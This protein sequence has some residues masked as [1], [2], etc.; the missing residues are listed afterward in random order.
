MT[1]EADLLA[2]VAAAPFDDAPRLVLADWWEDYGESDRAAFVRVQIEFARLESELPALAHDA[3]RRPAAGAASASCWCAK[4]R[5]AEDVEGL[6]YGLRQ[7]EREWWLT[8]YNRL[9]SEANRVL[10]RPHSTADGC[11]V[12]W[13]LPDGDA[14][15]AWD[16]GFPATV[17]LPLAAFVADPA[18]VGRITGLTGVVLGD[19]E[20]AEERERDGGDRFRWVCNDG[21][22]SGLPEVVYSRLTGYTTAAAW[23]GVVKDYPTRAAALAALSAAALALAR[24]AAGLGPA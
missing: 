11:S 16:R 12:R 6:L 21:S 20:P 1:G 9:V 15:V 17:T 13:H 24:S 23:T 3:P 7:R 18:R 14:V 4:C 19:R 10:D 2:A 8:A 5:R 22:A